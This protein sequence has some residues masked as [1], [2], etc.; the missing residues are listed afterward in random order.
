MATCWNFYPSY[1]LG[2]LSAVISNLGKVSMKLKGSKAAILC[3]TVITHH[4]FTW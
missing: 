1:S 4:T 2:G 3:L